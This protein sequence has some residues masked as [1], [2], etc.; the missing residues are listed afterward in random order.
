MRTMNY[1]VESCFYYNHVSHFWYYKEAT[2]LRAAKMYKK[3]QKKA[4]APGK[5]FRIKKAGKIGKKYRGTDK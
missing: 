3:W 1:Y 2:S 4:K 5:K